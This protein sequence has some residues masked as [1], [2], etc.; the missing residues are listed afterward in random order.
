M[1][2]RMGICGEKTAIFFV[3]VSAKTGVYLTGGKA[4]NFAD[5]SAE[6]IIFSIDTSYSVPLSF[7]QNRYF[8]FSVLLPTIQQTKQFQVDI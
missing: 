6:N 8:W 1:G 3:K 2:A 7:D 5:M 4:Q